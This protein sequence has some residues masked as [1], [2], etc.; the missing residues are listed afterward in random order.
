MYVLRFSKFLFCVWF[1]VLDL[2]TFKLLFQTE[3]AA[4]TYELYELASLARAL[5]IQKSL[6][7][8]AIHIHHRVAS[9]DVDHHDPEVKMCS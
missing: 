2:Q 5:D 4:E 3:K 8:E 7:E 1:L 6:A 9:K